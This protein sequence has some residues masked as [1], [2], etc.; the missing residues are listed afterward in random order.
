MGKHL[1]IAHIIEPARRR[2]IPHEDPPARLALT[3]QVTS[4]AFDLMAAPHHKGHIVGPG[5]YQLDILVAAEN[6]R[7]SRWTIALSLRGTWYADEE[8]MLR[9]GVGA[10]LV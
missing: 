8:R 5:E 6:A 2:F 10:R 4:L 9:D 7:P 3:D 1:D